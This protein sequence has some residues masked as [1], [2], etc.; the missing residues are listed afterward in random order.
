MSVLSDVGVYSEW[1]KL[2]FMG[3]VKHFNKVSK[4]VCFCPLRSVPFSKLVVSFFIFIFF[5]LHFHLKLTFQLL[6]NCFHYL[7]ISRAGP[8]LFILKTC[9][10]HYKM[11]LLSFLNIAKFDSSFLDRHLTQSNIICLKKKKKNF[12]QTVC[13]YSSLP[14]SEEAPA[15]GLA[16]LWVYGCTY[17]HNVFGETRES[18]LKGP[19]G[20]RIFRC[21]FS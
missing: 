21:G 6:R 14:F 9:T 11:K 17:S 13:I 4:Y 3:N 5:T 12:F 19:V 20:C 1:H 7:H 16:L 10:L 18:T 2:R 15:Y 8:S